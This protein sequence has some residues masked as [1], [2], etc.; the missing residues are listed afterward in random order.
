MGIGHLVYPDTMLAVTQP[1]EP[2]PPSPPRI[3]S[4]I[5]SCTRS[6]HQG[7]AEKG[8]FIWRAGLFILFWRVQGNQET[9]RGSEGRTV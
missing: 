7:Y 1:P 6:G 5:A 9:G 8:G 4:L 3:P 2:S